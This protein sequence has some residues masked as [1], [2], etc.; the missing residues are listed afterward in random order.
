[1]YYPSDA[2]FEKSKFLNCHHYSLLEHS[3]SLPHEVQ[4]S[5]NDDK[6]ESVLFANVKIKQGESDPVVTM[7]ANQYEQIFHSKAPL[8]R[9][10]RRQIDHM[11]YIALSTDEFKTIITQ[12]LSHENKQVFHDI[13]FVIPHIKMVRGYYMTE[14]KIVDLG[15]VRDIQITPSVQPQSQDSSGFTVYFDGKSPVRLRASNQFIR[16]LGL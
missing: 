8:A 12:A 11:E 4:T 6:R 2:W 1:V 10:L 13:Y 15:K 16:W 14:M 9:M 7:P 3:N 5:A